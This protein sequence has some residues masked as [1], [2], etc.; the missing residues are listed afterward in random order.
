MIYY[1]YCQ[2][3]KVGS[4]VF[5]VS[6]LA[7]HFTY[8][9]IDLKK[10]FY[11]VVIYSWF[12]IWSQSKSTLLPQLINKMQ[13]KSGDNQGF[14]SRS[15]PHQIFVFAHIWAI[16]AFIQVSE[17]DKANLLF[18]ICGIESDKYTQFFKVTAVW[19]VL[20]YFIFLLH[21]GSGGVGALIQIMIL[22]LPQHAV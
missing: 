6:V 21:Y 14:V 7:K 11:K 1:C 10:N 9:W 15:N 5:C 18:F 12:K 3:T 8:H 2:K 20:F 22:L 13:N 17:H 4:Y 16:P 19:A